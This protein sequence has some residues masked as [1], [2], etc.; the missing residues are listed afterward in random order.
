MAPTW[1]DLLIAVPVAMIAYT[2]IETVSNMSEEAI[3]APKTVPKA[4][5]KVVLAVVIIYAA[6][7]AIALSALPVEQE[8]NG[9][10]VTQLGQSEEEG[11]YAGDPVLGVVRAMNLGA[12]EEP[13]EVYVGLLAASILLL[14]ANA[15]MFGV[16]RLVYSM[17]QYQQIPKIVSPLTPPLQNPV[18]RDRRLFGRRGAALTRAGDVPGQPIRRLRDAQLHRRAHLGDRPAAPIS[19]LRA[20][21]RGP[22]QHHHALRLAACRCSRPSARSARALHSS[23]SWG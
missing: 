13:A 23:S 22:R 19:G 6:L 3:D 12:F 11:G 15:G 7:P 2:G 8:P 17:G 21:L 18:H 1:H 14:A 20:A 4:M 9:E 5:R 16:S 10:Y